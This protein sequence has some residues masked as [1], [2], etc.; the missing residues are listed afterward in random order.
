MIGTNPMNI[1]TTYN[2]IILNEEKIAARAKKSIN[3]VD[4][5]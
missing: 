2:D 5:L 4:E 1:G 3:A